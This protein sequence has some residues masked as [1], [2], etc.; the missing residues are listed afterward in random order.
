MISRALQL[1]RTAAALRRPPAVTSSLARP[2]AAPAAASPPGRQSQRPYGD[3]AG[4]V[5]DE[6]G[7]GRL[8]TTDLAKRVAMDR[9]ITLSAARGL[10]DSVVDC[11]TEVR[12]AAPVQVSVDC[13]RVRRFFF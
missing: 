12:E 4:A 3:S 5:G 10:V 7:G 6:G 1:S 2:H 9:G 8:S 13:V 11:I